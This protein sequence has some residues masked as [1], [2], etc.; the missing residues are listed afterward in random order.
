MVVGSSNSGKS[1]LAR[2]LASSLD[3]PFVE[4]DALYWRPGWVGAPDDEFAASVQQATA[5][6]RWVVAGS[7]SRVT[8]PYVWPRAECVI[9]FDLP[10]H[11]TMPRLL[12]R[13]WQRWRTRELLWGTNTE[14]FWK[15]LKLWDIEQSLPA[16][17]LRTHW[18]RR[19][20]QLAEM[21]DPRWAHLRFVRLRSPREIEAFARGFEAAARER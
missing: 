16:Y 6:D 18:S 21:R 8:R 17:A 4:L 14:V 20:R 15:H 1:T 3:A 10:L 13:S 5:G 11:V 9:W 12:R 7:Y 2:R 19:R